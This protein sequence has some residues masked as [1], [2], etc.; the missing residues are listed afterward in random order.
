VLLLMA[1]FTQRG[2][3]TVVSTGEQLQQCW[4][5]VDV[6]ARPYLPLPLASSTDPPVPAALAAL[7]PTI[8]DSSSVEDTSG[9]P[10]AAAHTVLHGMRRFL[11]NP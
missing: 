2:G 1:V 10:A 9:Q 6:A 5:L 7:R 11:A 8:Q 3:I 4:P